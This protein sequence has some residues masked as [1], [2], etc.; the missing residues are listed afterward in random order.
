MKD[1]SPQLAENALVD[2]NSQV[3]FEVILERI[4]VDLE[5][6]NSRSD[7]R[8]VLMEVAPA[9]EGARIKTYVPIFLRRDALR[10]LQGESANRRRT[11][12]QEPENIS[13]GKEADSAR[14]ETA[15]S[16]T[17]FTR[18]ELMPTRTS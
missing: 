11:K 3:D 13:S 1:D 9:Y 2:G 10:R 16:A 14:E 7:I 5:G 15:E 6:A 18:T 12:A 4:W 8:K 17:N